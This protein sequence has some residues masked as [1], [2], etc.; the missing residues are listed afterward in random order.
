L[1]ARTIRAMDESALV[2]P[3]MVRAGTDAKYFYRLSPNVYRFRPV[4]ADT[5][6]VRSIHGINEHVPVDVYLQAI[7]F[8]YHMIRQ[9]TSG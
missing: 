2:A 6:T 5:Q 8:Y 4:P 7:R 9:A 1:L 3:Y